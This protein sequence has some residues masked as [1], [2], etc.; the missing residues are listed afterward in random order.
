MVTRKVSNEVYGRS[1]LLLS[2]SSYISSYIR[3]SDFLWSSLLQQEFVRGGIDQKDGKS[4]V[5]H[6]VRLSGIKH[7]GILFRCRTNDIVIFIQHQDGVL[8]HK[9]EL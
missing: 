3:K 5:Q 9:L 4:T 1:V 7:M 6:P 2:F 8:L